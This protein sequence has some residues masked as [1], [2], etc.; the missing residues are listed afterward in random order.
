M[1]P[2][3][4]R[5]RKRKVFRVFPSLWEG[6]GEGAKLS[7]KYFLARFVFTHHNTES[8]EV[9]AQAL[10]PTLSQWEREKRLSTLPTLG[11]VLGDVKSNVSLVGIQ[12]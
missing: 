8:K 1:S 2:A 10:T 12:N 4:I 9:L 3:L 11:A 6:L 5:F 7:A